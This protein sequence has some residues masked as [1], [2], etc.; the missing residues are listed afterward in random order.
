MNMNMNMNMGMNNININQ[1]MLNMN[2]IYMQIK[3]LVDQTMININQIMINMNQLMTN[4]NKMNQLINSVN[5]GIQPNNELNNIN[6]MMNNINN[7][8]EP[9]YNTHVLFEFSG[10]KFL[11]NCN[12]KDKLKDVIEQYRIKSGDTISDR[13]IK[14]NQILN[15]E[16][17][18]EEIGIES[19]YGGAIQCLNSSDL[20]G[21]NNNKY[22]N[23]L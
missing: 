14:N 22:N 9:K 18:I 2:Q 6:F 12:T 4:M 17:T 21:G 16:K 7:L 11:V 1:G 19:N 20:I 5:D 13:F 23:V 10:R 3:Q 15:L 8:F